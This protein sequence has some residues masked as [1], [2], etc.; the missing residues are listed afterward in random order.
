MWVEAMAELARLGRVIAY[1]RRGC[2]RSQRPGSYERTSVREQ[3]ADA[4]ALLDALASEAA[5]VIGRSYGGAVALDLALGRPD[6]VRALVLLEGDALGLVPEAH[7]WTRELRDQLVEVA[8]RDGSAAVYPTLVEEVIGTGVWDTWPAEL[9]AVL[10]ANGPAL[11]AELAYV[12][13]P[14]P[15]AAELAR[16]QVPTLVVVADDSPEPQRRMAE[17]TAEAL[18][19]ARLHRIAGGHLIDPAAPPVLEFVAEINAIG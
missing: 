10:N 13:D 6:L 18:P 1:D 19:N 11:L 16:I 5:V 4:A 2:A 15:G 8:A 9:R 14:Q 17:A 7:R 3:A 12:D